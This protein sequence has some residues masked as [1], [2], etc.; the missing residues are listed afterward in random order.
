LSRE[1]V[2][3]QGAYINFVCKETSKVST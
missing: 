1:F 2:N 3:K